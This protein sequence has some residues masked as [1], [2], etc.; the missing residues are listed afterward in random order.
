MNNT[1]RIVITALLG[2]GLGYLGYEVIVNKA[3]NKQALN[4]I[5]FGIVL[6]AI[7]EYRDFKAG[8]DSFFDFGKGGQKS[9]AVLPTEGVELQNF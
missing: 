6:L 7:Y 4:Y 3:R 1:E 5:L 8:K 9:K 2:S